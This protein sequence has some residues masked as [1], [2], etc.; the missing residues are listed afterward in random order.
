MC[1]VW[2][3]IHRAIA[4]YAAA[5]VLSRAIFI[6][7][8]AAAVFMRSRAMEAYRGRMADGEGN[9]HGIVIA[10]MAKFYIVR[11]ISY[12]IAYKNDNSASMAQE[13]VRGTRS[14]HS[15]EVVAVK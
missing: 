14:E 4:I 11:G 13:H 2:H 12:G 8:A 1:G 10:G 3:V 15:R 6:F 9:G 7:L 5:I